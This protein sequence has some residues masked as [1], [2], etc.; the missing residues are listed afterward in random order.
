MQLMAVLPF[1]SA[2]CLPKVCQDL[3]SLEESPLRAQPDMYP[4]PADLK[5]DPNGQQ[6]KWQ[7]VVL[8][9]WLDEKRLV[10]AFNKL[11][12]TELNASEKKRNTLG[13]VASPRI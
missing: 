10:D 13:Y 11:V 6:R 1:D 12:A 4:N 5:L 2:H 9:P 7:W 8:L 3:M